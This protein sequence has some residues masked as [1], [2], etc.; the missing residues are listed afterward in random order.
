[1]N[2]ETNIKTEGNRAYEHIVSTDS[3]QVTLIN[4]SSSEQMNV[5]KTYVEVLTNNGDEIKI[6]QVG[7][8]VIVNGHR[9]NLNKDGKGTEYLGYDDD[10]YL[11]DEIKNKENRDDSKRN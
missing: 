8:Y 4:N 6:S 11:M 1:M 7:R 10:D 2:T 5:D 3:V 9:I